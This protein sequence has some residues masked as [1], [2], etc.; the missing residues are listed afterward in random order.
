[1]L[2]LVR[3]CVVTKFERAKGQTIK[4]LEKVL[5]YILDGM[6]GE[7]KSEFYDL[8][9]FCSQYEIVGDEEVD[10]P[11]QECPVYKALGKSCIDTAWYNRAYYLIARIKY[12]YSGYV[13]V[14]DPDKAIPLI[15]AIKMWVESLEE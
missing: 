1:M 8:C 14:H 5:A 9:A 4:K 10:H 15:L 7:A 6:Y 12:C 3:R 11:C 2:G 13:Y